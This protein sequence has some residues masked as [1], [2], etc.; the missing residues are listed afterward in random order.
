VL[1]DAINLMTNAARDVRLIG[2]G[3]LGELRPGG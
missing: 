3:R 2:L 1:E